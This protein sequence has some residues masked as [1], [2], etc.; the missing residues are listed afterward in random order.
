MEAIVAGTARADQA[1]QLARQ[2]LV[3]QAVLEELFWMPW[4]MP[5]IDRASANHA[6]AAFSSGRGVLIS[7]CH[8]GAIGLRLWPLSAPERRIYTTAAQWYFEEPN[9]DY[10]GRR[11]ARW[12]RQIARRNELVIPASGSFALLAQLL[13]RGDAVQVYFDM[14][15]GTRTQFLGKPVML[16]SGSA[17]LAL[18]TDA[19]ILPVTIRREGV[20][21]RTEVCAPLDPRS[22]PDL[23]ELQHALAGVHES[24]ILEQPQALEDPNR[25]G[26]WEGLASAAEWANPREARQLR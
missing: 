21:C 8:L 19:L 4:R 13:E 5:S 10:L 2:C 23:E 1:E 12:W 25:P 9:S 6:Q 14:P 15:G 26:A 24:L 3:E 17:R 20:G 7:S 11:L 22:H 18:A 16:S